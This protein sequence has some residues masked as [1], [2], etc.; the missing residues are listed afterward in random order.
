ME[1]VEP[2]DGAEGDVE[3]AGGRVGLQHVCHAHVARFEVSVHDGL[4]RQRRPVDGPAPCAVVVDNVSA[5]DH[6]VL[7]EAVEP[8][9]L[10]PEL[11]LQTNKQL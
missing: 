4:V 9:A 6:E 7:H 1:A 2:A 3:L 8:G 5:L 11:G 10:V